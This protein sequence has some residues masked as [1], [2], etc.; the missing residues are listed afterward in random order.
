[1]NYLLNMVIFHCKRLPEGKRIIPEFVL[2]RHLDCEIHGLENRGGTFLAEFQASAMMESRIWWCDFSDHFSGEI[3]TSILGSYEELSRRHQA[4]SLFFLTVRTPHC[5]HWIHMG[6]VSGI[7]PNWLCF[8]WIVLI[9][10][11]GIS[12]L[13]SDHG[14]SWL[15]WLAL[16]ATA[17][18]MNRH[19]WRMPKRSLKQKVFTSTRKSQTLL[20]CHWTPSM[21]LATVLMAHAQV[22]KFFRVSATGAPLKWRSLSGQ[23]MD[24]PIVSYGM[25]VCHA[26][27]MDH[28]C[29]QGNRW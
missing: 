23:V 18:S 9:C 17:G 7:I 19:C 8:R 28:P 25:G 4:S 6:P 26:K 22:W 24:H 15:E 2:E 16:K 11:V 5:S 14:C 29:Y 21:L 20:A 27:D 10:P 12:M 13:W 3:K 1:M